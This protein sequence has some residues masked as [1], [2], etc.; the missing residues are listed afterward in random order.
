[1]TTL[2]A[3][4]RAEVDSLRRELE[5]ERARSTE[6]G[7][8]LRQNELFTSILAHDLRNP[9]GALITATQLLELRGEL[10]S[11]VYQRI[12]SSGDRMTRMIDQ[13]LDYTRV[14]AGMPLELVPGDLATI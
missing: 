9:L 5:S 14:R 13:L 1:M 11:K 8:L 12:R 4:L 3:A 6:L 2:E 10:D 7:D